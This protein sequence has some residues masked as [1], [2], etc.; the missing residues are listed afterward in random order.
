MKYLILRLLLLLAITCTASLAMAQLKV[1]YPVGGET[2]TVGST[3]TIKWSGVAA[4][5]VV[6][7]EYSTDGGTSWNLITNTATGLQYA[8]TNI[9]NTASNNCLL[10]ITYSQATSG[11]LYL[12]GAATLNAEF[13]P[14]GNY[15]IGSGEDGYTYIWD[16]HTTNV[17]H[18]FQTQSLATVPKGYTGNWWATWAPDGKTFASVSP[19][20]EVPPDSTQPGWDNMVR[21]WDANTGAMLHQWTVP[22]E[23]SGDICNGTCRFSPDGT[24]IAASGND[25]IRVFSTVSGAS[26]ANC[27][28]YCYFTSKYQACNPTEFVDWSLDGTKILSCGTDNN[29]SINKYIANDPVSGGV[30]QGYSFVTQVPYGLLNVEAKY[31]PDAKRFVAVTLDTMVRI[32]DANTGAIL[33]TK[34]ADSLGTYWADYSHDGAHLATIGLDSLGINANTVRVWNAADFSYVMD[35][36]RCGGLTKTLSW[37]PDDSRIAVSTPQGAII[38]Q[39]AASSTQIATSDSAWSIVQSSGANIVISIPNFSGKVNDIVSTPVLIDN[40]N[41]AIAAGATTVNAVLQYDASMLG[42]VGSTPVG[43]IVGNSRVI[44][45]TLTITPN[46]TVL[47]TLQFK[48]ALGDDSVT[49]MH[50]ANPSSNS[51]KVTASEQD[52]MFTLL[53]ICDQGGPRLVNPNDSTALAIISPNPTNRGI[54]IDLNIAEVGNT[55]LLLMDCLGRVVKTLVD[56][57]QPLGVQQFIIEAGQVSTGKYFLL[58][59]TPTQHKIQ[60]VEVVR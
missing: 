37:S 42:P 55:R 54:I 49:S 18:K 31:C 15:V 60:Q 51:L 32:W 1:V 23:P 25:S 45:L 2:I 19:Q 57:P 11:T 43:S 17:V 16:S 34:R 13:S 21:T 29:D 39:A 53:N 20:A 24:M 40:P 33:Y 46:D 44:P 48:V 26:L 38:F 4:N 9:P 7:I 41:G 28:G 8:W 22:H 12:A 59:Q 10:R 52:G 14:D 36:G 30:V 3:I 6:K 35:V 50:I 56:G 58:L 27:K 5:A 47:T